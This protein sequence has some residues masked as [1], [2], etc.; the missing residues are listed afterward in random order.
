MIMPTIRDNPLRY[1]KLLCF[2]NDP[3]ANPAC[4]SSDA[5]EGA[6]KGAYPPA[7]DERGK[8]F[9]AKSKADETEYDRPWG[10]REEPPFAGF[11][12]ESGS[13]SSSDNFREEDIPEGD[14][15]KDDRPDIG[16]EEARE[17][18]SR[19]SR[20]SCEDLTLG[21]SGKPTLDIV[22]EWMRYRPAT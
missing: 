4:L 20:G 2:S 14:E 8:R 10:M 22:R 1:V 5:V 9:E 16:E 6:P 19:E 13:S 15:A 3:S 11:K 18:S 7:V 21:R 17:A 12:E